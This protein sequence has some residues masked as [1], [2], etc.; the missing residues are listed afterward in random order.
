MN[1]KLENYKSYFEKLKQVNELGWVKNHLELMK[2]PNFWTIIEYGRY[3]SSNEKSAHETRMSKM[4]RW[5]LDP[6]ENHKLGNAFAY[7]ILKSI[8]QDYEYC[9]EKSKAIKS[10]SEYKNIDIF[11]KDKVQ[12]VCLAIEL[13][14][15]AKEGQTR[16]NISQLDKYEAIVK[17]ISEL[18]GLEENYI[19]LTPLKEEA[20]NKN[21]KTMGYQEFIDIIDEVYK[22]Y[23]RDSNEVY[24]SDTEK[25]IMDFKDELQRTLDIY[26]KDHSLITTSISDMEKEFTI[27]LAKEIQED[28]DSKH[29]DELIK[30]NE[31]EN[32]NIKEL[33]LLVNDH[34]YLQDH[35]PNEEVK[36]LVRKIYNFLSGDKKLDVDEVKEYS[37][38]DTQTI[39]KPELLS[40]YGIKFTKMELT[41]GKGQGIN[42]YTEDDSARIYFSGDSKGL[43]PN[44]G[45]QLLRNPIDTN[46]ILS[47][48]LKPRS[49][50]LKERVIVDDKIYDKNGNIIG[51]E[52]F[53]K[54]SLISA[55][56]ELS[57]E[58]ENLK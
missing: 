7:K 54:E 18:E 22:E 50:E 3:E 15:H 10:L 42:M 51:F 49:Y 24:M 27:I 28:I 41:R 46:K 6:N 32:L 38:K 13:K 44:D 12:N 53:M 56:V 40:S 19:F 39:T 47:K 33:V 5:M 8:N 26:V 21:W 55:L 16:E 17:E 35:S 37:V 9:G 31:K 52:H 45:V 36:I 43:F 14:Q 58:I 25:I 48:I 4:I 57:N 11:Y 29:M 1:N 20:S 2:K 23:I 30:L 34:L